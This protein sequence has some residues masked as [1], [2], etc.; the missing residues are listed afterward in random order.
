MRRSPLDDLHRARGACMRACQG[1][2]IPMV[3]SD[4]RREYQAIQEGVGLIDLS[5]RG[6]FRL[7]GR[8]RRTWFQGMIT[9]D[10]VRLPDGRGAYAALLNPQGHMLSDLRVFA[11]PDFLL[12]DVPGATAS[13]FA[14]HL[15]HHLIME[16]VEIQDVTEQYALLSL[17][18][19]RSASALATC[20]GTEVR[21]MAMW[22]VRCLEC[23][24]VPVICARVTHCGED[25]YDLFLPAEH[26]AAFWGH[27]SVRRPEF[28]VDAAG[29][30]ALNI[31]RVEAGIPWWGHDLDERIV[32]FEARLERTAISFS[33][34]CYIGQ[35]IVARIEARGQVNNLLVGLLLEDD[36]LPEPDTPILKADKKAGRITSAVHSPTLNR[37]IAL[38]FV[39]R[40]LSTPDTELTVGGEPSQT[41]RVAALPFIPHDYPS[42]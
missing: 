7:V 6:K 20:L 17:Q 27:L 35:E 3:F 21:E 23:R 5:H 28:A 15:D 14:P 12:V 42:V 1:C 36:R 24:H 8:D 33:K 26:A 31:R 41:V 38:G 4:W 13:M 11:L 30:E 10:V 16:R 2:H 19:P 29:W 37:G 39:R 25:G 22:E 34:G 32:P 40:A 9:Q 18:G